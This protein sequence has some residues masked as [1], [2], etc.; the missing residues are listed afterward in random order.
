MNAERA[1]EIALDDY[2]GDEASLVLEDVQFPSFTVRFDVEFNL[3]AELCDPISVFLE[4][5]GYIEGVE[6]DAVVKKPSS[7]IPKG[8]NRK[9]LLKLLN[10]SQ[11]GYALQ[12]ETG[13]DDLNY[14]MKLAPELKQHVK[15]SRKKI[16]SLVA[17]A[18]KF[19]ESLPECCIIVR[20]DR[21]YLDEFIRCVLF[22]PYIDR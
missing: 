8:Y 2:M 19:L 7:D 6:V 20:H 3:S 1:M 22:E 16:K 12:G 21:S 10:Y 9:E 18:K 15:E 13:A 5:D 4:A 14:I 17:K 11:T